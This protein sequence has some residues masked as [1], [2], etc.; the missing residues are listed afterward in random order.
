MPITSITPNVTSADEGSSVTFTIVRSDNNPLT[1]NVVVN[2]LSSSD[3]SVSS[4]TVTMA[5]G[6]KTITYTVTLTADATTEGAETLSITLTP[7]TGGGGAFT[8]SSVTVNDTSMAC[9]LAG[10]R[11]STPTGDRVIEDLAAGDEILT[12]RGRRATVKFVS[13]QTILTRF[14][15]T[16]RAR[17]VRISAGALGGNLPA[18][19][20]L[21]SPGHAVFVDG[22]LAR[23]GALVNGTTITQSET[24]P[25]SFVYYNI[26]CAQHEL[27]LAEG[28]A[29]ESFLDEVPRQVFDNYADYLALHGEGGEMIALDI[30][31]A[32][33]ARQLPDRIAERLGL[34]SPLQDVA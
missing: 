16:P 33:T 29:C 10:T 12:A 8:S 1:Y 24:M 23:A 17:P 19:D 28:L 27:I 34:C 18:R 32:V 7:T 15:D 25:A 20:L 26:E 30:P 31:M 4:S 21:V 2:G 6:V 9:F 5:N 3:Y 11:I 22:I 13:R 14:C